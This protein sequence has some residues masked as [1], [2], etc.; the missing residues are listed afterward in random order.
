MQRFWIL[1]YGDGVQIHHTVL[2]IVVILHL[3]PLTQRTQIV[4]NAQFT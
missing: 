2:A 4:T 1:A 3:F